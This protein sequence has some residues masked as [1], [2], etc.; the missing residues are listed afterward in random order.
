MSCATI[1]TRSPTRRTLPSRSVAT[2]SLAPISFKLCSRCLNAI[3]DVREI[4]L[5]ARIFERWAMTSSV[6]PSAKYSFSGSALRLRNGRTATDGARAEAGA[7]SASANAFGDAH[8]SAGTLASAFVNA[9]STPGGTAGRSRRTAGT[10]STK[11][12]VI[13]ACAV[14]PVNGGS[15]ASISYN[16][17]PRLYTSLRPSK[18]RSLVACSGLM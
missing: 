14:G 17:Q 11:H 8:R 9:C 5:R 10:G 13:T 15:P 16:T 12:L 18:P 4:T 2:S 1:R 6:I 3:T 7:V